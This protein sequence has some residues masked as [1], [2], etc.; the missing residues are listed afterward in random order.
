MD[1][2]ILPDLTCL[3]EDQ[4]FMS[5]F[6][7]DQQASSSNLFQSEGDALTYLVS[8]GV[9]SPETAEVTVQ[10]T[11]SDVLDSVLNTPD[12]SVYSHFSPAPISSPTAIKEDSFLSPYSPISPAPLSDYFKVENPTPADLPASQRPAAQI[13]K[14][15][16]LRYP[17]ASSPSHK[18]I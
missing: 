4:D 13:P 18:A 11:G 16:H 14:G 10:S 17:K 9:G 2:N 12:Y 8:N 6:D 1:H 3:L 7:S 5:L 15:L